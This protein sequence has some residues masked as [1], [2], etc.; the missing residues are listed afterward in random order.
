[1]PEHQPLPPF[2]AWAGPRSPKMLVIGEAWGEQEATCRQPF[3]GTSGQE[4]FRMLGEALPTV[5]PDLWAEATQMFRYDNAWIGRRQPWL[6]AAG[7]AFTNVLNLR[8]PGNKLDSLC[9]PKSGVP[10][11]YPM[12]YLSRGQYLRP[13]YLPELDR[14]FEEIAR[15]KP[16]IIVAAGNTACWAILQATNIGSIRGAITSV[17]R[18]AAECV[19]ARSGCSAFVDG[20]RGEIKVLATYHPAGV[21]RQWSWRPIV[22]ADLMKA[23]REAEFPDLRRPQR[24]VLINPTLEECEAWA[25]ETIAMQPPLLSF[26]I[27]TGQQQ[28]KCIGFGRSRSEALVVPFVD[29][30]HPT[31]SYWPTPEAELN[32]WSVVQRLLGSEIPKVAQNG[33]YDLQYL[34][35]MGLTVTNCWEDTMLLHHSLFPELRKGLG[36]LGSI[37][38]SEMSWKLMRRPRADTEKRD[39]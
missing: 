33:V 13:E 31:G 3:V 18:Y 11:D 34:F 19:H 22:V 29:L 37:Y 26:D 23:A 28:I 7:I 14:L 17:G 20:E 10:N 5:A 8:P 25:T 24:I 2:A 30:T 35:R 21:L 16:N 15:A 12:P 1:V 39:E 32:A 6:Q 36:F 38:T 4:L 9:V 27:E